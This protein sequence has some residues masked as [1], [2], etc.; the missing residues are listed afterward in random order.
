MHRF[1]ITFG[2]KVGAGLC[3]LSLACQPVYGLEGGVTSEAGWNNDIENQPVTEEQRAQELK[4]RE[5][6]I[7]AD[8]ERLTKR[9]A[10][11]PS[12]AETEKLHSKLKDI[13]AARGLVKE[14]GRVYGIRD[15]EPIL[16]GQDQLDANFLKCIVQ[17]K[18]DLAKRGIDF[19][20]MPLPPTPHVYAH[21]LVDGI[22]ADNDYTPGWTKMLLQLLE[23]DVEIIDP[24]EEYRAHSS[25][26]L[27]IK[28]PNDFHTG[29]GGRLIAA[30]ALAERLQR[31][32][33][34]RD[35]ASFK[36]SYSLEELDEKMTKKRIA[37]VNKQGNDSDDPG[38]L[39]ALADTS[40][41]V[42][43]VTRE[44]P[45]KLTKEERRQIR[46]G[47]LADPMHANRRSDLVMIGDSQLHA[48]VYGSNWPTIAM[49]QIGGTFRWGSRSG[50]I[51]HSLPEIYLDV[52]PDFAT[53]PRVVVATTMTKYFWK[54]IESGPKAL[55]EL[56]AMTDEG[57]PKARFDCTVELLK[58]SKRPA[59]DH[60]Q[61]DYQNALFHAA[62]KVLDG[63]LAGREIGIRYTALTKKGWSGAH[64]VHAVGKQMKLRLHYWDSMMKEGRGS[65]RGRNEMEVFDDT[66]QDLLIPIFWVDAGIL[67]GKPL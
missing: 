27:V 33:F 56:G 53:Q 41:K 31:Y 29:S 1:Y 19:I 30:Q 37:V 5:A 4:A 55:P 54:P 16:K 38:F 58:I 32:Q 51:S 6:A 18:D 22:E 62:A 44:N 21:E 63:P 25:D 12:A 65:V 24:I 34:A 15:I 47:T 39:K 48:A 36:D 61:L 13:V 64:K 26:D 14:Q 2:Q 50:P 9:L 17:L 23:N 66:N 11:A 60:T 49:S 42:L 57:I 59:E 35:L 10:T 43:K 46:E 45:K 7:A 67:R 8:K 28:W 20:F 52:V 40:F 3:A